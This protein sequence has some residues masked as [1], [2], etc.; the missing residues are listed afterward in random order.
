M[1]KAYVDFGPRGGKLVAYSPES[2][3]RKKRVND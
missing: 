3:G 1:K 2:K